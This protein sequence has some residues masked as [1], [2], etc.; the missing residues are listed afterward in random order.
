[1]DSEV[2]RAK[3]VIKVIMTRAVGDN[4]IRVLALLFLLSVLA[5]IITKSIKPESTKKQVEG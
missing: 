1:M 5:V 4:C 2:S 3:K